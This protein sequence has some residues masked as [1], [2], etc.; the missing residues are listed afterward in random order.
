MG[1]P[2]G[3][4]ELEGSFP[5]VS[6]HFSLFFFSCYCRFSSNIASTRRCLCILVLP[7]GCTV[8]ILWAPSACYALC[9][10]IDLEFIFWKGQCNT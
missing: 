4:R 7:I 10:L 1:R 8:C 6:P 5:T 3:N 9:T 2:V